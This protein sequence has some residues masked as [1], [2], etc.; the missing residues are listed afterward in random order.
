VE[1]KLLGK[2]SHIA[3]MMTENIIAQ[4]IMS[5]VLN[6]YEAS[7]RIGLGRTITGF[8]SINNSVKQ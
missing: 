5:D 6:Y 4:N 1:N 2:N 8:F 7:A 3:R